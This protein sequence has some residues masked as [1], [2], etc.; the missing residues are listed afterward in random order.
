MSIGGDDA[1]DSQARFIEPR[2]HRYDEDFEPPSVA[3]L[4]ELL[5]QPR[6]RLRPQRGRVPPQARERAMRRAFGIAEGRTAVEKLG[7]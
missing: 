3:D 5:G 2:R 1:V 4:E 7:S 6:L